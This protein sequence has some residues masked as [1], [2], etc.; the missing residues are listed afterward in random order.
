MYTDWAPEKRLDGWAD[1]PQWVV[2]TPKFLPNTRSVENARLALEHLV[3]CSFAR[4]DFTGDDELNGDVIDED[5]AIQ[6]KKRIEQA[7]RFT[8]SNDALYGGI[9]LAA[10][11]NRYH[12]VKQYLTQCLREMGWS[13]S[14]VVSRRNLL[15]NRGGQPPKSE[16]DVLTRCCLAG[17]DDPLIRGW[18]GLRHSSTSVCCSTMRSHERRYDIAEMI[19]TEHY[20]SLQGLPN[21]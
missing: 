15:G 10:L 18:Q 6:L 5:A 16:L 1:G 19:V 7:Y 3:E 12:P 20:D 8:P 2:L 14:S 13:I 17:G 11:E 9:K 4:N 21:A